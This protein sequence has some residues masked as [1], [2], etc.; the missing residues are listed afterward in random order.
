ML[1]KRILLA[2]ASLTFS[3][4]GCATLK[5]PEFWYALS[6]AAYA[7]SATPAGASNSYAGNPNDLLVFGG[8]G[9]ATFLGCLSCSVTSAG[10]IL[11]SAGQYGSS[12]GASSILNRLSQF[13][14]AY[15][16]YSACSRTATDPP[17]VVDRKGNCYGRLTVNLAAGPTRLE[18][19]IPWLESKC[20]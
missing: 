18:N 6:D 16:T 14:S 7:A 17:V 11:N 19:V 3:L 2:A 4:S 12:W 9:H 5:R 20:T 13:G 8:P 10:S 1:R 15:S